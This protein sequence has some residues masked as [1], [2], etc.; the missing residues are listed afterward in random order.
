MKKISKIL[1]TALVCVMLVG[2]FTGCAPKT[3]GNVTNNETGEVLSLD[4]KTYLFYAYYQRISVELFA[5]QNQLEVS[6]MLADPAEK[7]IRAEEGESLADKNL[8][9]YFNEMVKDQVTKITINT[10]LFDAEGMTLT[11]EDNAKIDES[12]T[13]F[14]ESLGADNYK[15]FRDAIQMTDAKM[16]NFFVNEFK[17]IS[18]LQS[19]TGEGTDKA[20]TNE[21]VKAKFDTD[22]VRIKHIL[23]KNSVSDPSTQQSKKLEGDA[24][25][26]AKAKAE[27]LF[28]EA[29]AP[30]ANFEKLARYNSEDGAGP[31]PETDTTVKEETYKLGSNAGY[32]IENNGY[33]F[34]KD[35]GMV[36][37]FQD[38][39]FAM[40]VGEVRLVE[41]AS[42][43]WHIM[44]KYDLNET[45]K[46]FEAVKDTLKSKMESKVKE[47]LLK[48]TVAKYTIN[49]DE[50][51]AAKY[52]ISKLS[53][54]TPKVAK[55][56]APAP[57]PAP[58]Q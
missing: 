31:D 23:V 6:A 26:A 36:K 9:Q 32:V 15:K 25:A 11:A 28:E 41:T 42:T 21:A 34:S 47:D 22:Y 46:I 7:Y 40:N 43:G 8:D 52:S 33:T 30:N 39:A 51:T 54:V 49:V 2:V 1:A 55:Q 18:Y 50:K 29:K 57:A 13:A 4:T 5:A 3:I 45:P 37:E 14:K 27:K 35:D 56:P 19:K 58:A 44:K 24:L 48:E 38:A 10:K 17:Q 20:I 16:R 53:N 12:F